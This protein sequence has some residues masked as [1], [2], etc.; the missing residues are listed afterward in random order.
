[1]FLRD[2]LLAGG[3]D[4][5]KPSDIAD[6]ENE[7]LMKHKGANAALYGD[8]GYIILIATAASTCRVC[9]LD[10]RDTARLVRLFPDIN[11]SIELHSLLTGVLGVSYLPQYMLLT[12]CLLRR[13]LAPL[14]ASRL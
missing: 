11:V 10:L 8:L 4:K 14:A 3:E 7:L 6:A 9:A 2:L 1:M 5:P 12:L 13:W